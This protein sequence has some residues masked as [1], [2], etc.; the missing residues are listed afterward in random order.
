[1]GARCGKLQRMTARSAADSADP[2]QTRSERAILAAARSLFLARGFDDV[3]TE[4]IAKAAGVARQTLFNRF[5]SKDAL[6]RAVITDHWETWGRSGPAAA[7]AH[8]D[9]VEE[10]LRA[11]ALSVAAFQD[12]PEQIQFQ[13]LIVSES[14]RL[15][16]L[17]PAAYRAGKGPRMAALAAHFAQLHAE[18]RLNCPN[19]A[20]AAWQFI[21]LIQEFLVW[22]KVMAMGD[23]EVIPPVDTVIAEAIATFMAR[24]RPL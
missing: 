7:T 3:S 12:S 14:R 24:Y 16:W 18:G 9:P 15:D 4:E 5:K 23:D 11:I 20:I 21:G 6:F 2:R 1:M 17:G 8:D 13:R 10:H 19:P 22:P